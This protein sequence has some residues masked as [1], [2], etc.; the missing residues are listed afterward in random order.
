MIHT[1]IVDVV[2]FVA[3]VFG[4]GVWLIVAPMGVA[5][6]D[7]RQT[8]NKSPKYFAVVEHL[9][10]V[11]AVNSKRTDSVGGFVA[12]CKIDNRLMR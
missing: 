7:A 8:P 10:L 2:I 12:V 3:V 6:S 1:V 11:V 4:A 5:N 9:A